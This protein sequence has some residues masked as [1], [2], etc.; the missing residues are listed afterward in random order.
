[1]L[2]VIWRRLFLLTLLHVD[3]IKHW[4]TDVGHLKH[5]KTHAYYYYYYFFKNVVIELSSNS[6]VFTGDGQ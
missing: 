4:F 6:H 3:M 1:M 5:I 2:N